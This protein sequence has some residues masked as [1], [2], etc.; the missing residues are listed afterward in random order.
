MLDRPGVGPTRRRAPPGPWAGLALASTLALA[1]WP[2]LAQP[3]AAD[4]EAAAPRPAPE[5]EAPIR[6]PWRDRRPQATEEDRALYFREIDF[7]VRL[8]K[9]RRPSVLV[10]VRS[11]GF[12]DLLGVQGG[13]VGV[14]EVTGWTSEG[15]FVRALLHPGSAVFRDPVYGTVAGTAQVGFDWDLFALGVGGGV[16]TGN[17]RLN[18]PVLGRGDLYLRVGAEPGL[19]VSF[20]VGVAFDD[21][22]VDFG[23]ARVR[24]GIAVMPEVALTWSVQFAWAF[25]SARFDFGIRYW[26]D[27]DAASNSGV[28]FE[29]GLMFAGT[30]LPVAAGPGIFVG[31][32]ARAGE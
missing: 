3:P 26:F 18:E 14:A 19:F 22:G 25:A 31:L 27:G 20:L 5:L 6:E 13:L 10:S 21:Q 28:A 1:A 24:W 15:W 32:L 16:G 11:G 7:G 23:E 29:V 2:A 4:A 12:Y 9:P 17:S 30:G 8:L